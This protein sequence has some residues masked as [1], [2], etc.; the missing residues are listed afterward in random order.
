MACFVVVI[1]IILTRRSLTASARDTHDATYV[2]IPIVFFINIK[3]LL[4]KLFQHM[5]L[6]QQQNHAL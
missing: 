3:C 6:K 5:K 1:V 2:K 4:R